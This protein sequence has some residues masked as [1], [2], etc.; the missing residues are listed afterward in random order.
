MLPG[1]RF[2]KQLREL[3]R[4]RFYN[5]RSRDPLVHICSELP[6]IFRAILYF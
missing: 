3:L 4:A 1:W 6:T 5:R 2:G